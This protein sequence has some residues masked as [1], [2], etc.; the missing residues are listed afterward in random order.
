MYHFSVKIQLL[1]DTVMIYLLQ[2]SEINNK[3]M[4]KM[5]A[6]IDKLTTTDALT[7]FCVF[8]NDPV[9]LLMTICKGGKKFKFLRLGVQILSDVS[10]YHPK[11]DK[12]PL[13]ILYKR[14]FADL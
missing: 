4:M 6:T 7:I 2:I 13:N 3:Y 10:L 5:S 9:S 8:H 12:S 1:D 11:W 14:K